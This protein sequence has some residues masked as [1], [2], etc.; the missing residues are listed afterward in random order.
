M[1]NRRTSLSAALMLILAVVSAQ[2]QKRVALGDLNVTASQ[3][4][5]KAVGKGIAELIAVEL[6]KSKSVRLVEREKRVELMKELEFGLSGA[7]DP[8]KVS[9]VG[10]M[11]MADYLGFGEAI[12][13][14]PKFLISMKLIKVDTGEIVWADKMMEALTNYEY[15]AG[16]FSSSILKAM[17]VPV[18]ATTAAK[19]EKKVEKDEKAL[20]AFSRAVE[21]VDRKDITAA[22]QELQT[23]KRIDPANE[24]VAFYIAKLSG[25]SPRMQV[26]IDISAA[27]YNPAMAAFLDKPKLYTW[28]SASADMDSEANIQFGNLGFKER[29]LTVRVGILL[30]FMKSF[31]LIAEVSPI[32]QLNSNISSAD[33]TP[34]FTNYVGGTGNMDRS[35]YAGLLG[36]SW[37]ALNELSL[38][39][40][41]RIGKYFQSEEGYLSDPWVGYHAPGYSYGILPGQSLISLTFEGGA[42]YKSADDNA[43]ADLRV[44]YSPDM[45]SY[46]DK[47][48]KLL[49]K[50][51]MPLSVSLGGSLGFLNRTLFAAGRAVAELYLDDRSGFM[52]R[53]VPAVE[54]WPFGFLGVRGGY[55]FAYLSLMGKA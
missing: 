3:A 49:Q 9:Q 35:A 21:A 31:G 30:P 15:I 20:V 50:G 55:E 6:V 53:M 25:S 11:L 12:E 13:M 38:G 47:D 1:K 4:S 24:A 37:R 28:M 44:L 48:A 32:N 7:A 5:Y 41:F 36:L 10:E 46:L 40:S 14:G 19:V 27:S 22:K 45:D 43:T 52:L 26:E 39:A 29:F 8:S 54:W 42:L 33:N 2:E 17:A 51:V 18:A 34:I 16:F 23:A